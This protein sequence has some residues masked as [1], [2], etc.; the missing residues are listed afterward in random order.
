[1]PQVNRLNLPSASPKQ[2]LENRFLWNDTRSAEQANFFTFGYSGRKTDDSESWRRWKAKYGDKWEEKFRQRYE[3]EMI[4]KYDTHFYVGTV[5]Q[6][7]HIWIIVGLY[8]PPRLP[9]PERSLF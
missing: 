7:P 1:M 6:H 9:E 8:Y 5:K 3:K 2:Q 4:E